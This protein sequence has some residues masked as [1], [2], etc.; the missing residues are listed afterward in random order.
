LW[1]GYFVLLLCM[2]KIKCKDFGIYRIQGGRK[3]NRFFWEFFTRATQQTESDYRDYYGW[4]AI[5]CAVAELEYDHNIYIDINSMGFGGRIFYIPKEN[6]NALC[7]LKD[8]V[9]SHSTKHK[10]YKKTYLPVGQ[11]WDCREEKRK[12]QIELYAAIK[13]KRIDYYFCKNQKK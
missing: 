11:G 3:Y 12:R 6:Q 4:G 2:K 7:I 8:V 5:D 10:Q 13:D 1:F 9:L